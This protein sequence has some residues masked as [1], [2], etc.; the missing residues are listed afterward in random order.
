MIKLLEDYLQEW[1]TKKEILAFL[2]SDDCG[3][4]TRISE[5]KWRAI[6]EEHNEKFYQHLTDQYIAHGPRGYK[7]TTDHE[8]MKAAFND[9][10]SRGVDQIKKARAG[11]K[12]IGENTNYD[13]MDY[14]IEELESGT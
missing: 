8:E 5:R 9:Y 11:Y 1:R 14:I 10:F 2:D 3:M 13:F 4:R 6:V 12:A 7:L